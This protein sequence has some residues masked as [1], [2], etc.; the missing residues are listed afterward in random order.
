MFILAAISQTVVRTI[1]KK[2][3]NYNNQTTTLLLSN[4]YCPIFR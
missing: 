3:I 2:I 4:D 1:N